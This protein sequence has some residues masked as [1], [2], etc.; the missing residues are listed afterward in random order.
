MIQR[1]WIKVSIENLS[2]QEIRP[3]TLYTRYSFGKSTLHISFYPGWNDY[4][5]TW[6]INSNN[7]QL[8]FDTYR[9]EMINDTGLIISIQG[10]RLIKF[11][12]EEYLS[13]KAEHLDSIGLYNDKPLFRANYYITPRYRKGSL[14]DYVQKE[15][16]GFHITK[17]NYFSATFIVT[18]EGR[19][20][21]VVIRKGIT[22]AFDA[23]VMKT[24]LKTSKDWIPAKFRGKPIQTEMI[25][26]IKYL[27]A[28]NPHKLGSLQ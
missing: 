1:D 18:E 26:E 24:L 19:V 28:L 17:A 22:E 14:R 25:Y 27:D 10:F 12:S 2:D 13:G 3:D 21:S 8:T 7:L 15:L 9:I 20:E 11:L 23:M 16:E 6:S 5:Q 4:T